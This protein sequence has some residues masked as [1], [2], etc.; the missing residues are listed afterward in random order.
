MRSRVVAS[1][2]ARE[3]GPPAERRRS[4][5]NRRMEVLQFYEGLC[6]GLR[7]IDPVT[8]SGFMPRR[9]SPTA[10]DFCVLSGRTFPRTSRS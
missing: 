7:L 4:E 3:E 1:T 8:E 9:N 6:M 10:P 5:S 2:C